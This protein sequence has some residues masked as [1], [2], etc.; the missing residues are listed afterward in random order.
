MT[1]SLARGDAAETQVLHA[2]LTR[3]RRRHVEERCWKDERGFRCTRPE[4]SIDWTQNCGHLADCWHIL[5]SCASGREERFLGVEA[6]ESHFIVVSSASSEYSE[7]RS[8]H[9]HDTATRYKLAIRQTCNGGKPYPD[10]LLLKV[11]QQMRAW[12][13]CLCHLFFRHLVR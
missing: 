5:D 8:R 12:P 11:A 3:H 6:V 9:H 2:P 10:L 7:V 13:R 1:W 4:N